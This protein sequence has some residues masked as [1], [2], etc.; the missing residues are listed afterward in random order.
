MQEIEI[1]A[2]I[3]NPELI[4]RVLEA[5]QFLRE[6]PY[7]QLDIILDRPD[8]SLFRSG[9]K[10]RIRVE[11]GTAEITYKGL[12]QGD[13]T[14]SRRLE[15]NIPLSLDSV[16]TAIELFSELGF[17]ECFRIQKIR[18]KYKNR[19]ISVTIDNWPLIGHLVEIEGPENDC[20]ALAFEIAPN[21]VFCN[22]RLK[23]LLIVAQ[24][25]RKQT[26]YKMKQDYENTTGMKL[27]NIEL[28][29]D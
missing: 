9:K 27:G 16:V 14:A 21:V 13:Y 25:K 15:V 19:L 18:T 7:D 2:V 8:A 29:L 17:P 23:D 28:L 10:L 1:R 24:Q 26:L 5:K 12:F 11:K 22:Y 3:D 4:C 6:P 20:K